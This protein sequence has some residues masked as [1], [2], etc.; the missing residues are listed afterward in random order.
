M[1]GVH[2]AGGIFRILGDLQRVGLI[3]SDVHTVH[4][5]TM[6]AAIDLWDISRNEDEAIE[7]FFRAAPG[8]V[9]TTEA[10]SQA[11]RWKT[12][13]VD[14]ENGCIRSVVNAYIQ[15]GGLAVLRGNIALDG[16]IVNIAGV[17][18]SIFIFT[19]NV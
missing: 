10:F 18:E 16:C 4:A 13:D 17:D 9:R 8:N 19:G 12:V 2:R 7:T 3:N 1:E 11:K 5:S 6:G 15:D 14:D